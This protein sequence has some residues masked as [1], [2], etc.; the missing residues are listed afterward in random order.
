MS[1]FTKPL[2]LTAAGAALALAMLAPMTS[3]PAGAADTETPTPTVT[4]TSTAAGATATVTATPGASSTPT[5]TAAPSG[6]GPT[7]TPNPTTPHDNRFFSQT[8]FRVD[9]DTFW[10]YFNARGGLPTFGYPTSRTFQFLGFTTQFFQRRIM[11]IGPNGQAR[12]LN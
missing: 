12:L 9:N 11:Q 5:S 8:G 2:A 7:A 10:D 4:P 1:R 3:A 6:P